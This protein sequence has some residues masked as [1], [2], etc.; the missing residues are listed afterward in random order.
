MRKNLHD[1]Q[2]Q[3]MFHAYSSTGLTV[4]EYAF[5]LCMSVLVLLGVPAHEGP[6]QL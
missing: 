3:K 6:P 2:F 5:T 1:P 4:A